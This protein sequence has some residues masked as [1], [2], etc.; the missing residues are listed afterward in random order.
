MKDPLCES[1][2]VKKEIVVQGIPNREREVGDEGLSESVN[3]FV[4]FLILNLHPTCTCSC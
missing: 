3:S 4:R 2:S 1:F